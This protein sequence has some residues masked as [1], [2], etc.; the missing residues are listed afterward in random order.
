MYYRVSVEAY[1]RFQIDSEDE[2]EWMDSIDGK[3]PDVWDLSDSSRDNMDTWTS[4][5]VYD[6]DGH[7]LYSDEA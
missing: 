1:E 3:G 4:I 6:D 5:V 7:E 2:Q